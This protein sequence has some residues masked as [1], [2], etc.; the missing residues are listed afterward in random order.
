[1]CRIN[2]RGP[3]SQLGLRQCQEPR[4]L[5]GI[6]GFFF[7]YM[8][9]N[10][11][12]FCFHAACS[13]T[14]SFLYFWLPQVSVC[15]NTMWLW[16]PWFFLV[17]IL[18]CGVWPCPFYIR[19]QKFTANPWIGCPLVTCSFWFTCSQ[20][21]GLVVPAP[22]SVTWEWANSGTVWHVQYY[23]ERRASAST[24]WG[25]LKRLLLHEHYQRLELVIVS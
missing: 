17:Q 6:M 5:Y 12:S 15:H 20:E 25:S 22:G 16:F 23:Q 8:V 2:E 18:R 11:S 13:V 4:L 24:A 1:M 3:Q 7:K 14:P 10:V 9:L 21:D 19:P